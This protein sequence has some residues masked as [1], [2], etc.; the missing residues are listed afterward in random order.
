VDVLLELARNYKAYYSYGHSPKR[1]NP[2]KSRT[3]IL[4]PPGYFG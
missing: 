1:I 2:N 4:T 3:A